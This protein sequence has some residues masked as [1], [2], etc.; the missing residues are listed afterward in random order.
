MEAAIKEL[1]T[2]QRYPPS[3]GYTA[4]IKTKNV[5]GNPA[6]M[7]HK[8]HRVGIFLLFYSRDGLPGYF[9]R[10]KCVNCGKDFGG[11]FYPSKREWDEEYQRLYYDELKE[12]EA[13]Q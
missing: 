13:S 2:N 7:D 11:A 3:Y 12:I 5:C 6:F 4:P 8:M 1:R 10:K 9:A